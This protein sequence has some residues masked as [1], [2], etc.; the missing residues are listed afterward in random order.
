MVMMMFVHIQ[1]NRGARFGKVRLFLLFMRYFFP[2]GVVGKVYEAL[3]DGEC[4]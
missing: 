2:I 1:E 4:S 3:E